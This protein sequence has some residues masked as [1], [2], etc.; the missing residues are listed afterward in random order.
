MLKRLRDSTK[1][2][3]WVVAVAFIAT[4]V[5]SWG[6]GGF[7]TDTEQGIL[8]RID[9]QVIYVRQF[10]AAVDQA[11]NSERERMG[12]EPDPASFS[13]IRESVWNEFISQ[14]II[15]KQLKKFGISASSEEILHYIKENPP[16]F[17]RTAEIFLTNGL[18]DKAKYLQFLTDAGS[19]SNPQTKQAILYMENMAQSVI[20]IQKLQRQIFSLVKTTDLELR[21]IYDEEKAQAEAEVLAIY[22]R[23]L[24]MEPNTVNE[25]EIASYY[26]DHAKDFEKKLQFNVEYVTLQKEATPRDRQKIWKE[27]QTLYE[28]I[29][30]G[31]N[32]EELA[33][34]YSEDEF[35][36]KNGDL[37][38]VGKES[39]Q[40]GKA[41]IDSLF[42][43]KP[44][45]AT[46]PFEINDQ[47]QI[48]WVKEESEREQIQAR[49]ILVKSEDKLAEVKKALAG[50]SGKDFAELSKKYSEDAGSAANGGDLGFFGRG[51]MVPE[52]EKAA[53][54][55]KKGEISSPVKSQFGWHIIQCTDIKNYPKGEKTRHAFQ[56]SLKI[57][58]SD[59]TG[60]SLKAILDTLIIQAK[61]GDFRAAALQ[62]S[63]DLRQTGLL[64]R[65]SAIPQVGYLYGLG[66][67]ILTKEKGA[68]SDVLENEQAYFLFHLTD[69]IPAGRQPL[70]S[71]QTQIQRLILNQEK[72]SLAEEKAQRI[73]TQIKNGR[74]FKEIAATDSLVKYRQAGPFSLNGFIPGVGANNPVT[75][76]AFSK[77]HAPE[78][79]LR[80]E[81]NGYF[82][83]RTIKVTSTTDDQFSKEKEQF[84][85]TC[86]QRSQQQFYS[87]WFNEE[88][89]KIKIQDF[90]DQFY[91]E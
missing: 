76:A 24:P 8:G 71:V 37:G 69:K 50:K 56:I 21:Q 23:D 26:R 47:I 18:F 22:F 53:F 38:F 14:Y 40:Y 66:E 7:Q 79:P 5:W 67:F 74:N 9:D 52:F 85:Q 54:Q 36:E 28:R 45:T 77:S 6:M 86:Q 83:V 90:R 13:R 4:I 20:P 44:G 27:A 81:N 65:G 51:Q 33:K 10:Q 32:F 57:R 78:T 39:F 89:G 60:D 82:F 63:L 61:N 68:L 55:L 1:P 34:N 87:H 91:Y 31:E 59:L 46:R 15:S 41:V 12:R 17:I 84:R 3:L 70:E 62:E 29:K 35:A 75:F 64:E 30:S 43:I 42:R 19:Y 72:E 25:K 11:V 80:I 88:R 49:H 16:E 58:P 73:A 48:L 2:I